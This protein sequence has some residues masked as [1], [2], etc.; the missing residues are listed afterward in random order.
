[1]TDPAGSEQP[2][3]RP[4]PSSPPGPREL[5]RAPGERYRARDAG[6]GDQ[7]STETAGTGTADGGSARR[8]VSAGL[9]AAALGALGFA[10]LG[11]VD[12]GPG[13]V[14]VA[15]FVGWVV[16]LAVVWGA[17]AARPVPRQPLIAGA[18]G[19][20]AIVVGLV[21][22]WAW[23]RLTGGVLGPL[24]YTEARYG[25]LAYV[26]IGVAGVVAAARGR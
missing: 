13:L 24:E 15:A 1:M 16:A 14:A 6:G 22:A 2:G 21:L 11:Y 9:V 18:L 3:S 19:A 4:A 20:L 7:R 23:S 17:G 26:E 25:L 12:L 5:E 10:A 8:A